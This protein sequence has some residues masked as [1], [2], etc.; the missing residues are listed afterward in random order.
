MNRI[1]TLTSDFGLQDG[2]VGTM[3]G[4]ILGINPQATIVDITHEIAPQNV[5]QG[6]FLFAASATYFP[7]NTI[8]VVVVDPGVGTARRPIALQLGETI[9]VAPDNGVLSLAVTNYESQRDASQLRLTN[10]QTRAVHLTKPAYWLPRVSH[11]FHGRDIFA[12]VAAHLSLGTPVDALGEPIAD[13]IRLAPAAPVRRADGA[14]IAQVRHIDRFGNIVINVVEEQIAGWDPDLIVLV[15]SSGYL[16][17]AAR[18]AN[19][20]Q[21]LGVRI[22]DQI[23]VVP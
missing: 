20:A 19:A 4:A 1:I 10:S 22:G 7:A 15:S 14:L 5:E 21:I 18:E 9:F 16:E 23:V 17:V 2:F 8:H 11:T 13:W 12:P 6:A 3:K